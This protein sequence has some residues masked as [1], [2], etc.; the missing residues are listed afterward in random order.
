MYTAYPNNNI[1]F[2]NVFFGE[3]A[4][5]FTSCT[6][7]FRG[8]GVEFS[9]TYELLSTVQ[10]EADN[11]ITVTRQKFHLTVTLPEFSK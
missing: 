1:P 11:S 10:H 9:G 4:Y 5:P 2:A 8:V 6:I 3:S 7:G